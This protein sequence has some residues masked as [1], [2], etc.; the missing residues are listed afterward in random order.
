M[1]AL[2]HTS[3]PVVRRELRSVW[4][5]IFPIDFLFHEEPVVAT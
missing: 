1:E 2:T 5:T 3:Y 4:G